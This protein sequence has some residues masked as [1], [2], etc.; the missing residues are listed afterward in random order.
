MNF[1]IQDSVAILELIYKIF[2]RFYLLFRDL[3]YRARGI[4]FYIDDYN[5][6]VTVYKDGH[7]IITNSLKIKVLDWQKF[8][9]QGMERYFD[10]SE[11][12]KKSTKLPA[13]QD[14]IAAERCSRFTGFGFWYQSTAD[15]IQLDKILSD[16]DYYKRWTFKVDPTRIE[17]I[18]NNTIE[19]SYAISV[20]GLFPVKDGYYDQGE[21]QCEDPFKS[22]LCI[23]NQIN[24]IT[25]VISFD[26][27]VNIKNH[28]VDATIVIPKV[29]DEN[30]V[31]LQSLQCKDDLFYYRFFFTK[32]FP[33]FQSDFSMKWDVAKKEEK[34]CSA[35]AEKQDEMINI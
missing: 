29:N 20:P 34:L 24:R 6:T 7:G 30:T 5:K 4:S 2:C 33:K 28:I 23:K 8:N 15:I 27:E 14:M 19:L 3:H 17:L 16:G 32:R 1:T 9:Q 31:Q 35:N 10:I 11:S 25:Y 26:K 12:S 18:K 21:A 22:E 13:L